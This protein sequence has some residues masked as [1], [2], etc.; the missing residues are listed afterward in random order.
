MTIVENNEPRLHFVGDLKLLP[1]ANEVPDEKWAEVEGWCKAH[2]E[3]GRLR[4]VKRDTQEGSLKGLAPRV[5]I[6]LVK[7]TYDR[8][9]LDRWG[10]QEPRA[11]VRTAI[12][13]QV[14]MLTDRAAQTSGDDSKG[15]EE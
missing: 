2:L 7:N 4:V 14:N 13:A 8:S 12:A 6:E 11:A 3:A 10:V 5:A 1:G 9:L 15:Q